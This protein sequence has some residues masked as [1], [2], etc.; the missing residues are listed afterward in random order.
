M[1]RSVLAVTLL[2][3]IPAAAQEMPL[4]WAM[5]PAL[6]GLDLDGDGLYVVEE[7][8]VDA[9]PPEFDL[10]GDGAFSIV[11]LSQGYFAEIDTDNSGYL[12]PTELEVLS[13]VPLMGVYTPEL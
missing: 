4:A 13:G 5:K 6:E 12:E 1:F 3:A 7:L 9:V 11:E 10:D 8:A 2:A